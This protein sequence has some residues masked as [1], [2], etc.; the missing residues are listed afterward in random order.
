MLNELEN[1]FAE[2]IQSYKKLPLVE[3]EFLAYKVNEILKPIDFSAEKCFAI[4]RSV[5]NIFMKYSNVKENLKVVEIGSGK[6]AM[7][8]GLLWNFHGAKNYYGVDRYNLPFND[9]FWTNIYRSKILDFVDITDF[10]LEARTALYNG[11][12]N[13][14]KDSLVVYK[15]DFLDVNFEENSIDF[16]YSN[17]VFEHLDNPVEVVKKMYSYLKKGAIAYHVIDLRPH[18]SD[19][20]SPVPILKYSEEEWRTIH[21]DKTYINRLRNDDWKKIFTE[22]NFEIL[23]I[24]EAQFENITEDIYQEIDKSFHHLSLEAL[25]TRQFNVVL[26]KI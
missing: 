16:I 23:E 14:F 9:D 20:S 8:S 1:K 5:R 17:A 26:R 4:N 10:N 22:A 19:K 2:F 11:N 18:E 15:Q 24:K 7:L 12:W 13:Y 3:K 6:F 25:R 21:P